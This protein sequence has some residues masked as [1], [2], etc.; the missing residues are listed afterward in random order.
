MLA[1]PVLANPILANPIFG[2]GVCHVGPPV[3]WP[4]RL[5]ASNGWSPEGWCPEGWALIKA[6]KG[7][8]NFALFLVG[9]HLV[10]FVGV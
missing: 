9:G 5:G 10:E 3:G 7:A 4:Q 1:N 8:Q 2:S 6:P